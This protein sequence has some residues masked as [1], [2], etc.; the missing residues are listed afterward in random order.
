MVI[1]V[2]EPTNGPRLLHS[3][4]YDDSTAIGRNQAP[5]NQN[6]IKIHLAEQNPRGFR[7]T[8]IRPR[9]AAWKAAN[10]QIPTTKELTG[11]VEWYDYT[12]TTERT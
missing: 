7:C 10:F 8:N 6:G 4:K 9:N 1:Q 11:H 5:S 12:I 2:I 3:A